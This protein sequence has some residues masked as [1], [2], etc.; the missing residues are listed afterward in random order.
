MNNTI[1]EDYFTH[2]EENFDPQW[3][4]IYP[5]RIKL[6]QFFK[7]CNKPSNN[8]HYEN[9]AIEVFKSMR[10]GNENKFNPD[11]SEKLFQLSILHLKDFFKLILMTSNKIKEALQQPSENTERIVNTILKIGSD[12]EQL[13]ELYLPLGKDLVILALNMAR[14]ELG[15]Y[16]I[17]KDGS[18]GDAL[19]PKKPYYENQADN[20]Q[21][22]EA[23]EPL[24]A[25]FHK[26]RIQ[27]GG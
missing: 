16:K 12:Y 10:L 19:M 2:V 22:I 4:E 20:H 5:E 18:Y 1:F 11:D 7:E 8:E 17:D 15:M 25:G 13:E 14:E 9:Q 24:P 26:G 3:K 23:I 6:I 27:I 21:L